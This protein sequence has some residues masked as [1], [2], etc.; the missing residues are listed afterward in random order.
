MKNKFSFKNEITII[1]IVMISVCMVVMFLT[2]KSFIDSKEREVINSMKKNTYV[3]L[4]NCMSYFDGCNTCL[5]ENG[6]VGACTK[7]YCS[8]EFM[9]KSKCL[10]YSIKEKINNFE[11]CVKSGRLIMESYPRKCRDGEMVFTE[12]IGNI[13][14]K[15]DHIRLDSLRPNDEIESP[16]I[17]TGEARGTW[18]F[19]GDFSVILTNWDNLIIAETFATA[20]G[21]WMTEDFVKFRLELEFVKSDYKDS[22]TLILKKDNPSGRPELDDALE[23]PIRFK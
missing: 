14:E 18:F 8:F 16:L 1:A 7:K 4:E 3:D 11:D 20:E 19:E 6:K 17:I 13:I 15:I 9:G 12:N 10:K 2:L 22:G 5:V 23:I 21:D